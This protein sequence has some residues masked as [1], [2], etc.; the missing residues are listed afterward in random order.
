[1]TLQFE[2]LARCSETGARLGKIKTTRG[3]FL[4]PFFMPV[5]TMG[6]VKAMHPRDLAEHG[7]DVILSNAFHLFL[8]PGHEVVR[9]VGGIHKFMGFDGGILTD[10]GGY[11]V[12]S[13]SD[14][15]VVNDDGVKFKSPI[16]GSEHFVSPKKV[17]EIQTAL[18]AD[19][20]MPLDECPSSVAAKSDVE[21]AV[22]RTHLWASESLDEFKRIGGEHQS[23]FGIVQGGVYKDLRIQSLNGITDLEFPALAL[24]GFA[25]GEDQNQ[26]IDIL[27]D[28]I[29]LMPET[30]PRY[31]MGLGYPGDIVKTV[32]LGIDMFDCV[33]PTR[34]GRTAS[35]ITSSGRLNMK[36]AQYK[37]DVRP[38]DE[39][40]D[41]YVCRTYTR[42]LISHLTK[43]DN[44]S[45]LI[46]LTYHNL[47]F[48]GHLMIAIRNALS[49]NRFAE[50][51]RDYLKNVLI[52]GV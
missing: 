21:Q 25:V 20:I 32:A 29:P 18:G 26:M 44:I 16:D 8:R 6:A 41:C 1:M 2:I 23:L 28:I 46:L 43:Q 13:L 38:L 14:Y 35:A 9:D 22:R 11:Q 40:C 37:E 17:I 52:P 15:R 27:A 45:G 34:L 49:E 3:D 36:N 31:L 10:S 30:K 42:A 33:A 39:N 12:F 51:Y 47:A 24:G 4:T 48:Y 5:G 19:F 50:F 7:F